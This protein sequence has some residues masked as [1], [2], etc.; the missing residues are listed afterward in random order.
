MGTHNHHLSV[1][2]YKKQKRTKEVTELEQTI[3]SSK[4]ELAHIIFQQALAEQETEQIRQENEAV[5]KEIIEL[6]EMKD[7]LREQAD[8][9]TQDMEKLLSDHRKL[10]Q[11]QKKLQM[12]IK[13]M[14]DS[15]MVIERNTYAYDEDAEW[16]LPEPGI[17]MSAKAYREKSAAPLVEKLK[18]NI[19]NLTIKYVG[20]M[21]QARQQK[22]KVTKQAEDIEFYKG[23]IQQ[24]RSKIELLQ[25]QSDDLERVKQYIGVDKV[26]SIVTNV[27]EWELIE[28]S[29]KRHNKEYGMSL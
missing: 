12:E 4:E 10:E 27:R 23:K 8:E 18:S 20:L 14:N 28:R 13:R 9:L 21:D 24:Q 16:Q 7:L 3:S 26:N 2:D 29:R 25:E 11:K 19:K 1:L 5:R 17:L 6:S 15:K 22:I